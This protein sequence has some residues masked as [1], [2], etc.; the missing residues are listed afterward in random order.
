MVSHIPDTNFWHY[1]LQLNIYRAILEKNYGKK[2]SELYLVRLHPDDV[3]K[4]YEKIEIPMM[5]TEIHHLFQY[6]KNS[7]M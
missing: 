4:N 5:D 7:I 1:A 6:R 2:V 3:Y